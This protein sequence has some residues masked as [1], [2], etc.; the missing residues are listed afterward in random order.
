MSGSRRLRL[1]SASI[2]LS[3]CAAVGFGVAPA[4]AATITPNC[5][6]DVVLAITS[7][8]YHFLW[9]G[10]TWFHDGPG[11]SV[12][13]TVQRQR[14]ISATI[15]AG[16]EV[17][18]DELVVAA[19]ATVSS[20]VTKQMQTT[21]G[22]AYTHSIPSNKFGNLKYGGWGYSVGWTYEYRHSN[23]TITKIQTGTGTVPTVAQGWYYYNT[24]S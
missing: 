2:L 1:V 13:G 24:N 5:A 20:S 23:C 14:T 15:S 17:S 4:S 3:L 22:H 19:K 16:A 8:N 12:T 6:A 11:G 9:D 21:L 10:V 18:T 7:A